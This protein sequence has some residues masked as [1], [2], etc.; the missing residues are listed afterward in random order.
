MPRKI[1]N[2]VTTPIYNAAGKHVTNRVDTYF[3]DTPATPPRLVT[4]QAP[5]PRA[6][7]P[8]DRLRTMS[9]AE[10]RQIALQAL[11]VGVPKPPNT[12]DEVVTLQRAR[13]QRA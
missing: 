13:G 9:D 4:T 3:I 12:L 2:I 11:T 6:P 5:A 1:L 8:Q 7:T 10:R